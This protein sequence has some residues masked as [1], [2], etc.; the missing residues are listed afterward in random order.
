VYYLDE[1]FKKDFKGLNE[2]EINEQLDKVIQIF[3][4]LQD[5]D[6]FEGFYKTALAKRLLEARSVNEDAEKNLVLKLKEECGFQFTQKLE[7]MFKDI[8]MSEQA[9]IEFT[10]SPIA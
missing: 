5:K 2:I 1:K 4:Y 6:I 8:K 3:R 7:V 10:G 9:M